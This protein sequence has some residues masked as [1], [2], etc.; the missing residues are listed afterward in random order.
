VR[1]VGI[2]IYYRKEFRMYKCSEY[3]PHLQLMS[4]LR[5]TASL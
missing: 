5:S 2:E 4:S 1:D 3:L